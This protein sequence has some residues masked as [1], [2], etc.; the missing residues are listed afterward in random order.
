MTGHEA[1]RDQQASRQASSQQA[2]TQPARRQQAGRQQAG[3]QQARTQQKSG[4]LAMS[5]HQAISGQKT[6]TGQQAVT[7]Q[8]VI[9]GPPAIMCQQGTGHTENGQQ[10]IGQQMTETTCVS[11]Q[12]RHVTST[13]GQKQAHKSRTHFLTPAQT[14]SPRTKPQSRAR[15]H[16]CSPFVINSLTHLHEG[17]P[18]SPA[19]PRRL[20]R[21]KKAGNLSKTVKCCH[22]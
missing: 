4:H 16:A 17:V 11:Q 15:N 13:N 14:C 6:I 22:V 19:P 3:R 18:R 1:K 5:R 2:T 21:D 10:V 8:Q 12:Y 7:G 20:P 9:T